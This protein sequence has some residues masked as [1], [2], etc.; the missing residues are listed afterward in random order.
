MKK[1][2]ALMLVL[3]MAATM[4]AGCGEKKAESDLA[5]IEDKGEMIIGMTLFAPMNYYEGEELVGFEAQLNAGAIGKSSV[6]K[7]SLLKSTGIQRKQSLLQRTLTVSGT[8]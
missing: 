3:I 1:I 6:L 4:M 7:L 5:Y 8:V 2:L